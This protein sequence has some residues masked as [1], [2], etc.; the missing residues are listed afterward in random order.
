MAERAFS[1]FHF[2]IKEIYPDCQ[3]YYKNENGQDMNQI[4]DQNKMY[5][6]SILLYIAGA[7]FNDAI[8]VLHYSFLTFWEIC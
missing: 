7:L 6:K 3:N 1:D 5:P 8:F 2:S 4:N